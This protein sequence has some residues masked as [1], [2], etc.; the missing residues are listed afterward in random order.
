VWLDH[1]TL[2]ETLPAAWQSGDPTEAD[3]VVARGTGSAEWVE[4]EATTEESRSWGFGH[5]TPL[6]AVVCEDH[7]RVPVEAEVASSDGALAVGAAGRLEIRETGDPLPG[8]QLHLDSAWDDAVFPA[9][10]SDP[11][12]FDN[13]AAWIELD[14]DELGLVHGAAGWTGERTDG[15]S[16]IAISEE[17]LTFGPE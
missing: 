15:D 14:Y 5:N 1:V 12:D 4:V 10:T 9:S 17:V 16:A 11:A 8:V 7:L 13:K 6:I 2:D 3:V